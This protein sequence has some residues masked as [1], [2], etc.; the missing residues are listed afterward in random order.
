MIEDRNIETYL[1]V[2][3]KYLK[4]FLFDIEHQ[5][6]LYEEEFE[7]ENESDQIDFKNLSNF[8]EK[9]IFKIEKIIGR[10]ITNIYLILESN[11]IINHDFGIKKKNYE[12]NIDKKFIENLLTDAK[13]LFKENYQNEKIMHI[14]IKKYLLDGVSHLSFEDNF[15]GDLFSIELQIKSISRNFIFEINKVL[16]KYQIKVID[17]MDGKYIRNFF[18]KDKILF[19]EMVYKIKDGFN[20]NEVKLVPKNIKKAGFFE[21][22]FQLFS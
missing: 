13:D 9:N 3:P 16:E 2:T 12:K 11:K 7:F 5:N 14:L 1:Y 19:S 4:I 21:K 15:H 8:L 20:E 17:Y 22:F 6:N 10:F 18:L